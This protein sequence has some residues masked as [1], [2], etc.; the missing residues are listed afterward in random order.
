MDPGTVAVVHRSF[1]Q[2][3]TNVSKVYYRCDLQVF[4][5][6]GVTNGVNKL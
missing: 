3:T 6:S 2:N 1:S 5:L 4:Q